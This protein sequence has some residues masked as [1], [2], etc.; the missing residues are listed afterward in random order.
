MGEQN[1]W[2]GKTDGGLWL[3]FPNISSEE[4]VIHKYRV[5]DNAFSRR[6]ANRMEY[7]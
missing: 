7:K 3:P 4:L 5:H 2:Y 1:P 6:Q